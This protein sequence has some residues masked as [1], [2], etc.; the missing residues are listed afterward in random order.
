MVAAN[1]DAKVDPGQVWHTIARRSA[2]VAIVVGVAWVTAWWWWRRSW[3]MASGGLVVGSV[4][5]VAFVVLLCS[6]NGVRLSP[7]RGRQRWLPFAKVG[8]TVGCGGLV[9]V[10]GVALVIAE[11]SSYRVVFRNEATTPW[12]VGQLRGGGVD[13]AVPEVAAQATWQV[14]VWFDRDGSLLL[15]P[16]RVVDGYVTSGLGGVANVVRDGDGRIRVEHEPR[17]R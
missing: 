15:H 11:W 2:I 4:P 9:A 12:S 10:A 14:R 6:A 7:R 8:A 3:L 16:E 13:V 1:A 17:P 5:F